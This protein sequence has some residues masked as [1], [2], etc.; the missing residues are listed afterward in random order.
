MIILHKETLD[1]IIERF[2]IE[3]KEEKKRINTSSDDMEQ[4]TEMIEKYDRQTDT[5]DIR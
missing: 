2:S 1:E 3:C 5:D 4:F